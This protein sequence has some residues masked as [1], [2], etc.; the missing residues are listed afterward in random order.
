MMEVLV[1]APSYA[2]DDN[3]SV[4]KNTSIP[5]SVLNKKADSICYHE[6]HKAVM[7]GESLV[8]HIPSNE[9]LSDVC[10]KVVPWGENGE[11]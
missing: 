3:L 11:P 9:N 2:Y 1:N 8:A 7:M 5:K 4:V 6:V 10:T